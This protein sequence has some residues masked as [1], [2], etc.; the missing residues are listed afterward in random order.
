MLGLTYRQAR[1]YFALTPSVR[2]FRHPRSTIVL[3]SLDDIE[4]L[5]GSPSQDGTTAVPVV[6]EPTTADDVL[7]AVGLRRTGGTR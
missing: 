1:D 7:A 6:A 2:Q 3:V 5:L 4:A